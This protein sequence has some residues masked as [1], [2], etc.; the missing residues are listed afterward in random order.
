MFPLLD[1]SRKHWRSQ[2]HAYGRGT[3]RLMHRTLKIA[4]A[5]DQQIWF[6]VKQQVV[7][8]ILAALVMDLGETARGMAAVMIGYWIGTLM[9][10]LRRSS[11]PSKVD[12]LFARWGCSLL[13]AT[14]VFGCEVRTVFFR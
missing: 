5:Y 10:V 1:I 4:P 12:L 11:S 3:M 6:S 14:V 7:L 2:W 8:A 13:A 9:I